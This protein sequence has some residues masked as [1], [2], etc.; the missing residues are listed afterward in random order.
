M[1]FCSQIGNSVKSQATVYYM[2]YNLNRTDLTA[3]VM[4]VGVLSSFLTQPLIV[5]AAKRTKTITLMLAGYIGSCL[6]F[7]VIGISERRIQK[8]CEEGRID[9]VVRFGKV[10]AIPKDAEKPLDGRLKKK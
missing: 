6:G 1:Y 4:M 5:W 7:A 8:L 3:I 2:K 10:W 9:G